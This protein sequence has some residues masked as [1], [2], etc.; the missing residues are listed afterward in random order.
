[1]G[2]RG[3]QRQEGLNDVLCFTYTTIEN[4]QCVYVTWLITQL[5]YSF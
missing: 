1:M 5:V 2:P 4:F 3:D